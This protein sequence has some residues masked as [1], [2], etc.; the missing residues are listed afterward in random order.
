[1]S[2]CSAMTKREPNVPLSLY[3][4]IPWCIKKCP[5]CDFNSHEIQSSLP[6]DQYVSALILDLKRYAKEMQ[7]REVTSVF[8]GGGTPS[9]FKADNIKHLMDAIRNQL[10]L[11]AS[12]EITIEANPGTTDQENFLGFRAAGI[13]RISIGVQSFTDSQL[14]KLGRIH[15][16]NNAIN[17]VNTAK[18]AGF[19]NINIDLMYAL[20]QQDIAAALYDIEQAIQL[21]PT[22][23][24]YYQLTI[25]PNT[26]FYRQP[27]SLPDSQASWEIQQNGMELLAE[28]GY[29][30]YEVSAYAR[31]GNQCLHNIN[32]WQF[33]DYLGIGAGAHQKLTLKNASERPPNRIT[34]CEKP[35]H[36]QQYM[37]SI[38]EAQS[39]LAFHTLT[40][41]DIIF[42]F[43]LN[44]LRL[45]Q[46]F[47]KQQFELHTG[48]PI[49][50]INQPLQAHISEGLLVMTNDTIHCSDRGYRF[51]DDV[52]QNWLPQDT[53]S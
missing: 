26:S 12:A 20:P 19:E 48:I 51:L 8:I 17:A 42:E 35:K 7:D 6:E 41:K 28:H 4:H 21:N 3:V 43:M 38:N 47:T 22:H 24:S 2:L 45:K 53:L 44:A 37:R 14:Q 5:Y 49:E 46:G 40:E 29:Q 23:I 9:I 13:N 32:Y 34:R 1:M 16:A 18:Q 27:P 36:P 11:N 31:D 33:G 10:T 50:S 39:T 30:Q 52:L 25:E 15:N